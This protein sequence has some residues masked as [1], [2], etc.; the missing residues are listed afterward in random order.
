MSVGVWR[1]E[2]VEQGDKGRRESFDES[3]SHDH[4]HGT[5]ISTIKIYL[6]YKHNERIIATKGMRVQCMH[7]IKSIREIY[8]DK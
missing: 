3:K 6:R 1:F 7:V 5:E 2:S 4:M 8:D